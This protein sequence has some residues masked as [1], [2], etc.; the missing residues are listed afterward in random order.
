MIRKAIWQ[1]I[2]PNTT[3]NQPLHCLFQSKVNMATTTSASGHRFLIAVCQLNVQ[4]DLAEN[5]QRCAQMIERAGAMN[6]CKV[7]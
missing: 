3:K 1:F 7:N 4:H 2:S 5:F 6:G